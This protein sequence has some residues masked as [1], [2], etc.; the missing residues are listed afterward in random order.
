M[1]HGGHCWSG[2]YT[3]VARLG[4]S[5]RWVSYD[6]RAVSVLDHDPTLRPMVQ[7]S[8]YLLLYEKVGRASASEEALQE[9][10]VVVD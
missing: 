6:D 4:E 1:H 9:V 5:D 3:A 2:H 7:R 10:G 8:G